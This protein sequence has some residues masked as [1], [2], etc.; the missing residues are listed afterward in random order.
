LFSGYRFFSPPSRLGLSQYGELHFGQMRG[1][2]GVLGI[3]V[4]PQRKHLSVGNS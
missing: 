4:C 3:Q 2:F 1:L